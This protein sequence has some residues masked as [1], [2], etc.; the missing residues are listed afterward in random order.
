MIEVK[1][2]DVLARIEAYYPSVFLAGSIDQDK[3][4]RWQDRVVSMLE[5]TDMIVYNPRRDNWD[6]NCVQSADNPVFKEQVNWELGNMNNVDVVLFYFDPNG[7]APITLLELGLMAD[8][9]DIEVV[10]V[11]PE[12]YWRK[13]NVDIV[14]QRYACTQYKT[15]EAAVAY[16]AESYT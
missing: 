9:A 2:P 3:A 10:V 11:C 16:I 12:G 5:D 13:G 7:Q 15:L 6:P 8:R 4:E 1:A 14:C